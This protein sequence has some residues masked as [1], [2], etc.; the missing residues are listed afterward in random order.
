MQKMTRAQK[1]DNM[2]KHLQKFEE[3]R[4]RQ[5]EDAKQQQQ[6]QEE[7]EVKIKSDLRKANIDRL[8]RNAGFM[9]EWLRKGIEDWKKNMMIKKE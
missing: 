6:E 8:Q 7:L 1:L 4:R 3:T 9:E 2:D 5:E